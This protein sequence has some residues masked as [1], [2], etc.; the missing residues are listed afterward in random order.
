MKKKLGEVK[1]KRGKKD[2]VG[3]EMGDTEVLEDWGDSNTRICVIC[4]SGAQLYEE[5]PVVECTG[6]AMLIHAG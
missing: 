3:I 1:R 4:Q 5:N 6:C 2:E